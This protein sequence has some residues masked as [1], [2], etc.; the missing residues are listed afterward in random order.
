LAYFFVQLP[1]IFPFFISSAV[2]KPT[3]TTGLSLLQKAL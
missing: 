3:N 2:G 1:V